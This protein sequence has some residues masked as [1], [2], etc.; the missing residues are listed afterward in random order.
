MRDHT[1]IAAALPKSGFS[2]MKRLARDYVRPY[3]GPLCIAMLLM[4]VAAGTTATIAQLMQPVLDDVLGQHKE[5]MIVPIGVGVLGAFFIRGMATYMHVIMM[6]K[7]GQS[8]VADIQ[9]DLFAHFVRMDLAFFHV[10]PSGQLV[11][12]VVNDVNVVRLAVTES[13]TGIGKSLLTLILLAAVM[14][15]QDW[16]LALAAF[17]IAPFTASFVAYVGRRLRKVSGNIQQA[18]GHL[19]ARLS[20]IFQGIRQVH[21]YGMENHETERGGAAIMSVRKLSVKS[22]RIGNML[23]PVNETLIG[24]VAGGIIIYGGFQVSDGDMTTGQLVSFLAAFTLAYEPMKKLAR[25][26]NII[27]TGL[28]GAERIFGMMDIPCAIQDRPDAADIRIKNPQI[29]FKDVEFQYH[30]SDAKALN[31]ISFEAPPGKVT[32]LVGPSGGGKTT[33]INLIPRFYDTRKGK[34]LI[35]DHDIRDV[36]LSSL[37]SH[38][39]LVS[40]DITIFDDTVAANI[41]Y[42]RPDAD[43][44][45]IEQ[46]AKQAA[47]DHFIRTLPEGYQTQVGEDGVKLSGGQRQRIAIARALLRDAPILLLDE[48]TSAL[49][50]ESE[51]AVQDALKELEK[52]RTTIVIAHR[53]S[54]VR[55]ADQILVLDKGRIVERGTHESLMGQGGVYARMYEAGF[56][57]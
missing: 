16:K 36:K 38:I 52:G 27:Q 39:A 53:L 7:I 14:L 5:H 34:I 1:T 49:D 32:A 47:A 45:D 11:S 25:L 56:K 48:A 23:T 57:E 10:H 44:S 13:L 22:A 4:A 6:N 54:T 17:A 33:V 26:N 35:D 20:Q 51:Q 37:R 12:R 42:G 29:A 18:T 30:E 8:I 28:G 43:M 3:T 19:S 40:Q 24:L 31:G 15:M 2:L 55:T 9:K 50:N 46:A 21:A 41:A